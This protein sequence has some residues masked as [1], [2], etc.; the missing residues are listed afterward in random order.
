MI[1]GGGDIVATMRGALLT[2]IVC[3]AGCYQPAVP[4]GGRCS[5]SGDCPAGQECVAGICGGMDID[6]I[7]GSTV[8]VIGADRSQVRDTELLR[9][10]PDDNYGEQDHFSV[11]DSES[12]MLAFDL[13]AVPPGLT[14]VK[15]TLRVV[16]FD[17]A[18][19][20]GG[21]VLVYRVLE[22]W[23]ERTATWRQRSADRQW[24]GHGA[25]PPSRE[26]APIAELR[27]RQP[28]T[29]YEIEIPVDVVKGWLVDPASSFGLA[30]VRGT[31][32]RHVHIATRETGLGSTLTLELR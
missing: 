10:F 3:A 28:F 13:S 8:I 9:D 6:A 21:T 2:A 15:A 12:G 30:F 7:P 25:T 31:S 24:T 19:P 18:S 32:T 16:T 29:P 5:Q 1:A 20:D 11:D 26:P 27:P 17:E 4:A 22:S 23:D 14:P